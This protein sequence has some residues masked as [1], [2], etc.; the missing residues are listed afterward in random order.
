MKGPLSPTSCPMVGEKIQ[1][2]KRVR[3]SILLNI[4]QNG[5]RIKDLQASR[6]EI[7]MLRKIVIFITWIWWNFVFCLVGKSLPLYIVKW[8]PFNYDFRT[9]NCYRTP[10]WS[11]CRF[12]L[13]CSVFCE[14]QEVNKPFMSA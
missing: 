13:Y 10:V 9:L 5:N 4:F 11:Y 1:K 12:A 3:T 8:R 7:K 14:K 2:L 6:Q